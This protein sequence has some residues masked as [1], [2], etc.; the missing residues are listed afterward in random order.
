M[1]RFAML[2]S[3]MV[4]R[5]DAPRGSWTSIG[6]RCATRRKRKD[7]GAERELLRALAAERRRFGYPAW[8][9][10]IRLAAQRL[11]PVAQAVV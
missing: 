2:L 3:V 5:S 7:D 1:R 6:R 9:S 11:S 10:K 8:T 4:C